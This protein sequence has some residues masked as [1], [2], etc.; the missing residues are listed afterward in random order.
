MDENSTIMTLFPYLELAGGTELT[1][2]LVVNLK[3]IGVL[4]V[5][6][7]ENGYFTEE[8]LDLLEFLSLHVSTL[9]ENARLYQNEIESRSRL[10]RIMY[11][12]QEL[13]K[14]RLKRNR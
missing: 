7:K 11:H 5:S 3:T 2:P 13:M 12:Q 10:Q 1:V 6:G 4:H 14:K 8:D 9:I